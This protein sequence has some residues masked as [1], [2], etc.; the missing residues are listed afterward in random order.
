MFQALDNY[1]RIRYG[2]SAILNQEKLRNSQ[3][4]DM[5][6]YL[7]TGMAK[8]F[9]PGLNKSLNNMVLNQTDSIESSEEFETSTEEDS[10]TDPTTKMP[11]PSVPIT[12]KSEIRRHPIQQKM[13]IRRR[14]LVK[15]PLR[16]PISLP[17]RN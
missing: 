16:T 14:I 7:Q 6:S 5:G 17:P 3:P 9:V 15:L 4:K 8:W 11:E 13:Q 10:S 1:H 12:T 2:Y